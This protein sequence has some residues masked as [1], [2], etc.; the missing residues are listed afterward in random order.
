MNLFWPFLLPGGLAVLLW[1]WQPRAE[2]SRRV[3]LV[4]SGLLL[5]WALQLLLATSGGAVLVH[6]FGSWQ[7][8][9]GIPLAVDGLSALFVAL[10]AV[11]LGVVLVALRPA[12]HGESVVERAHPLRWWLTLGLVGAFT[13]GD[14]FNLFVSFEVVLTKVKRCRIP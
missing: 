8:P 4:G 12:A 1:L 11:L 10:H 6:R 7:P 13:T 2:M 3:S 14:L 9:F 5:L